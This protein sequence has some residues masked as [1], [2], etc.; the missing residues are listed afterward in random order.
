MSAINHEDDKRRIG[1]NTKNDDDLGPMVML[2]A[3]HE[4]DVNRDIL[5]LVIPSN[6]QEIGTGNLTEVITLASQRRN[7]LV[8][9]VVSCRKHERQ[10]LS[11]LVAPGFGRTC[12]LLGSFR[13]S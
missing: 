11:R 9:N 10:L 1:V 8:E 4:H 2:A 7:L 6:H 3:Q 13:F 12:R 5:P